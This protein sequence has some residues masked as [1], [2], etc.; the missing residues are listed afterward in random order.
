MHPSPSKYPKIKL[1]VYSILGFNVRDLLG[2]IFNTLI[3]YSQ[4]SL[5]HI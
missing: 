5:E 4:S 2:V 3:K 1:L